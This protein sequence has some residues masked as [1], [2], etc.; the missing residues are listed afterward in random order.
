MPSPKIGLPARVLQAPETAGVTRGL[1]HIRAE[2]DVPTD[3]PPEVLAAAERAAAA[4]RLPD[5][6]R[7]DLELLTIDPPGSK[8]LDQAL[9]VAARTDGGFTV[10]YAIADVAAFVSAGDP[11][12]LE[13]HR[14]GETFYGPD[15]RSPLHPPVLSEGAA[16]L[17]PGEVRPALLWTVE[18]DAHGRTTDA[19]VVRARV[20]SREQLTYE[21]AQDDIDHPGP[22]G[23]RPTLAL[24]AEVGPLREQRERERGGVSLN[25]PEQEVVPVDGGGFDLTYRALLPV[26]GWNA[27]ISLLTGMAAAHLMLYAR[28]GIVRTMP[29]ATGSALR[30]LRA[31]AKALGIRWPAELDYPELVRSLDPAR[32]RDAAMMNACTVL[33]RGAGYAAFDGSVPEDPE[34]AAIASD[35]S[36]VTAPLRR[37]VDRYAGEV[38]LALCAGTPVPGWVR[39][40]LPQLPEEMARADQAAHRYERAVVDWVEACLLQPRVGEV[41]TGT[42]VEVEPEKSRGTVVVQ[43]PA[44][45]ARVSGNDLPL[46]HELQVRLAAADPETGTVRFERA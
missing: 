15:Q 12:D 27:Q 39:D 14:R 32:P 6:D 16:S 3:F 41:F 43:D 19:G 23:T 46:G 7:T 33:F 9:H 25:L 8:D 29:P 22:G 20:R 42:V 2:L 38:C 5:L 4:P 44:V 1:E 18:L 37:L 28:V 17:L 40:A 13:A 11:V 34:H 35:Y 45:E 21:Q 24:L 10:S 31:V 30:R 26:E 36:H